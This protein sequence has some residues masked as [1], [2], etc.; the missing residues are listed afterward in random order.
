MIKA[1][2]FR[3]QAIFKLLE[4]THPLVDKIWV[5]EMQVNGPRWRDN[6]ST[7]ECATREARSVSILQNATLTD[8]YIYI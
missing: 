1:F 3:A 4:K 8:G 2:K 6:Y 7:V 5:R